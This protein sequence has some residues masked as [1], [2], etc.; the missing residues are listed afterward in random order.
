MLLPPGHRTEIERTLDVQKKSS[1]ECLMCVQ[2][3]SCVQQVL[4]IVSYSKAHVKKAKLTEIN[5]QSYSSGVILN[6]F[7]YG[8]IH[9]VNELP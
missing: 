2:Y 7:G 6:K 4:L 5:V 1:S 8:F 9:I 3:T